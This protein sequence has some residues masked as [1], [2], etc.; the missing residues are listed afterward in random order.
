ML[1]FLR[2]HEIPRALRSRLWINFLYFWLV[3]MPSRFWN[4]LLK[5]MRTDR[6]I[7]IKLRSVQRMIIIASHNL[8]RISVIILLILKIQL[9]NWILVWSYNLSRPDSW[10][11]LLRF[12]LCIGSFCF[13]WIWS[14]KCLLIFEHLKNSY[15]ALSVIISLQKVLI[16][17]LKLA[18]SFC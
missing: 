16:R 3:I 10:G 7:W 8:L 4:F 9:R 2:Y 1:M 13:K 18:F 15:I 11:K 6:R 17:S 5:I 14:G 12:N